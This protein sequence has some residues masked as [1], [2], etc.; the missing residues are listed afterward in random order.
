MLF[1]KD[2]LNT[3]LP[4]TPVAMVVQHCTDVAYIFIVKILKQLWKVSNYLCIHNY[5]ARNIYI[6]LETIDE[7][8]E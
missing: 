6:L 2:T 1:L 5:M 3:L 4:G 7:L 8:R